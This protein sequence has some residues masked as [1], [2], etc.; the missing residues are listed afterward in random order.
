MGP[1]RASSLPCGRRREDR[2]RSS[3]NRRRPR[4]DGVLDKVGVAMADGLRELQTSS[5]RSAVASHV[6]MALYGLGDTEAATPWVDLAGQSGSG[7][8]LWPYRVLLKQADSMGI[9]DWEQQ[10]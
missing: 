6:A 1:N 10:S 5:D 2:R 8:A 9:A 4:P 3:W 7:V